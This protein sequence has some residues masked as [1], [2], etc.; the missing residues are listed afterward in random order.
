[1]TAMVVTVLELTQVVVVLSQ[2]VVM[3][4]VMVMKPMKHAH[5]TVMHLENVMLVKY[6]TVMAREN[7]GPKAGLV[8]VLKIV[9]IRHMVLT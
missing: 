3:D 9:K 4:T 6:L 7:V 2:N 5:P 1:M 8:M